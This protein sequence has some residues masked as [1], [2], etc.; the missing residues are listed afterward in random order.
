MFQ[1]CEVYEDEQPPQA[2]L[3]MRKKQALS[4][5]C[6]RYCSSS[7]LPSIFEELVEKLVTMFKCGALIL[8][9]MDTFITFF[10][11]QSKHM[12]QINAYTSWTKVS[13]RHILD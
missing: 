2:V 7:S 4:Q 10:V 9:V 5:V 11:L 12:A 3:K 1:N 6:Y 8:L 13:H